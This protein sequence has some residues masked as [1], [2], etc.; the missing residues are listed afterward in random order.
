VQVGGV[1]RVEVGAV[2]V[3]AVDAED[4]QAREPAERVERVGHEV[5]ERDD[6]VGR[7]RPHERRQRQPRLLVGE[8]QQAHRRRR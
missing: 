8:D 1:R 2:V 6:R 4:G 3:V 5:A 7:V